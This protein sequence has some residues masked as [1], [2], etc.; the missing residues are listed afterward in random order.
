MTLRTLA[1]AFLLTTSF[2]ALAGP[3]MGN[4]ELKTNC[5]PMPPQEKILMPCPSEKILPRLPVTFGQALQAAYAGL[6]LEEA[7]NTIGEQTFLLLDAAPA[8]LLLMDRTGGL[9][10]YLQLEPTVKLLSTVTI[11]EDVQTTLLTDI[12]PVEVKTGQYVF[13]TNSLHANSGEHFDTYSLLLTLPDRID[14]VYEGPS[15]YSFSAPPPTECYTEQDFKSLTL[16]P[17]KTGGFSDLKMLVREEKSCTKGDKNVVVKSQN[18]EATLTWNV[19]KYM[20]GSKPLY[21][22]NKCRNDG[23]TNCR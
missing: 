20:G 14:V 6:K 12:P 10:S 21:Q 13:A 16:L 7:M 22:L 11:Q 23:K 2:P 3:V 17:T 4:I 1:I 15:L 8:R 19:K 5:A 9:L 18:F